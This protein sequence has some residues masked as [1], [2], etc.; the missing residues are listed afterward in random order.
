MTLPD[1]ERNSSREPCPQLATM[2]STACRKSASCAVMSLLDLAEL[3]GS[4]LATEDPQCRDTSRRR[5]FAAAAADK[6]AAG[7]GSHQPLREGDQLDRSLS[8]SISNRRNK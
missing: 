8:G 5:R 3:A 6:E 4:L 2:T 1:S 7:T